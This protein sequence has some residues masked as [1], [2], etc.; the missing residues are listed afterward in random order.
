MPVIL[1]RR[2][3]RQE[4]QCSMLAWAVYGVLDQPGLYTEI[5]FQNKNK[6]TKKENKEFDLYIIKITCVFC[7]SFL[8]FFSTL[9]LQICSGIFQ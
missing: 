1:A 8:K 7:V 9:K 3:Q 4:D 6:Q 2:Q 5:L